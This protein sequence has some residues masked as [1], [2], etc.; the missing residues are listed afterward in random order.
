L[1][2]DAI[3]T[4]KELWNKVKPIL[5]KYENEE[6]GCLLI[7]D[8]LLAKPYSQTN[9][10]ICWH[11]DHVSHRSQKGILMLNFHFHNELKYA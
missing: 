9:E 11:Y 10:V 6:D 4:D 1:L 5:R 8:S 3:E 7:D 2:D